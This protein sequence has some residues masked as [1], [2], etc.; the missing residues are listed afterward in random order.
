[1]NSSKSKFWQAINQL[2]PWR[3]G[4]RKNLRN[5][6][7]CYS[8]V[9]GMDQLESRQLLSVTPNYVPREASSDYLPT[10]EYRLINNGS[11]KSNATATQDSSAAQIELIKKETEKQLRKLENDHQAILDKTHEDARQAIAKAEE[12]H[13][14]QVAR[15]K[16]DA[17]K[18]IDKSAKNIDKEIRDIKSNADDSIKEEAKARDRKIDKRKE[19]TKNKLDDERKA[20][21]RRESKAEAEKQAKIDKANAEKEAAI[22]KLP[23]YFRGAA[24][25]LQPIFDK[26]NAA[27]NEAGKW[28]QQTAKD[29]RDGYKYY[30]KKL[31][32]E[33]DRWVDDINDAYDSAKKKILKES[34]KLVD[35]AEAGF[36]ETKKTITKARNELVE[37]SEKQLDTAKRDILRSRDNAIDAAQK[38]LA[39]AKVQIEQ[40][41]AKQIAS[42]KSSIK[43]SQQAAD[44]VFD[45]IGDAIVDT[46]EG[47]EQFANRLSDPMAWIGKEV[48]QWF[49]GRVMNSL[50]ASGDDLIT[51]SGSYDMGYKGFGVSVDGDGDETS[52]VVNVGIVSAGY[53][54][55]KHKEFGDEELYIGGLNV[56]FVSG[57]VTDHQAVAEK[58]GK[59]IWVAGLYR[60]VEISVSL[61]EILT[62]SAA[63]TLNKTGFFGVLNY[64]VKIN[65]NSLTGT[66]TIDLYG[67]L[68]I[69]GQKGDQKASGGGE[70]SLKTFEFRS[71]S[72]EEIRRAVEDR[73]D[74]IQNPA[75]YGNAGESARIAEGQKG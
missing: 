51:T 67:S 44:A 11:S 13:N 49:Q 60:T 43:E 64:G 26:L 52:A 12:S 42:V 33:R 50:S 1:M 2:S 65:Y 54:H 20:A 61:K 75:K 9:L 29:I 24:R 41:T 69:S 37:K 18:Q 27:I 38:G 23:K 39:D 5:R 34:D 74:R 45:T 55:A 70:G 16:K 66:T 30:E 17:E 31:L 28:L 3:R 15:V 71:K 59:P 46:G 6:R 21:E 32:A 47:I 73:K 58:D 14:D 48:N 8:R 10:M 22:N 56:P 7:Q 25:Y 40:E 63:D 4:H 62:K 57:T 19:D 72:E 36:S 35:K 53:G 68:G